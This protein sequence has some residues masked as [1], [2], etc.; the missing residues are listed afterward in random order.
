MYGL[1][2]N[3]NIQLFENLESESTKKDKRSRNNNN[4]LNYFLK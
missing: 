3:D 1:L 2:G 4:N